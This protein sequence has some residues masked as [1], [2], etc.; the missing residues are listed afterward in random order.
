MKR[1]VICTSTSLLSQYVIEIINKAQFYLMYLKESL[2][3]N[4]LGP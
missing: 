2:D 4:A 3:V 1:H